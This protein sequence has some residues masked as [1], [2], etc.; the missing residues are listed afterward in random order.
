M[1][2]NGASRSGASPRKWPRSSSSRS[3]SCSQI[4]TPSQESASCTTALARAKNSARPG[5][6]AETSTSWL[7][8]QTAAS[9]S[10]DE[11]APATCAPK[12]RKAGT[13]A[14]LNQLP[15]TARA[16]SGESPS[17]SPMARIIPAPRIASAMVPGRPTIPSEAAG[18]SSMNIAPS[19][20]S[21]GRGRTC[22][23]TGSPS[24]PEARSE[25]RTGSGA[26]K[27]SIR[28]DSPSCRRRTDASPSSES[29]WQTAVSTPSRVVSRWARA[30][31]RASPSSRSM[32]P[33]RCD[34]ST[35]WRRSSSGPRGA[36][37]S[38]NG[39]DRPLGATTET[40]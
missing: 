22:R 32:W 2:A 6:V 40:S 8:A 36:T 16:S 24:R 18:A 37:C 21:Q 33:V 38:S 30:P 14:G 13:S 7:R 20:H 4:A 15:A 12:S 31:S 5:A 3:A 23:P 17:R 1:R 29:P 11:R 26:W 34:M 9:A 10:A 39:T 28:I 19:R 35:N 27:R 25:A